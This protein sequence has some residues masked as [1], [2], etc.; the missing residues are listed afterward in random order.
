MYRNVS[1]KF[2]TIAN[3]NKQPC[4]TKLEEKVTSIRGPES[5]SMTSVAT[6]GKRR[7]TTKKI[8]SVSKQEQWPLIAILFALVMGSSAY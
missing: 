3:S 2:H 1:F 8:S 4:A 5:T 6:V 7:I